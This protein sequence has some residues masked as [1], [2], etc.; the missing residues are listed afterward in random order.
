MVGFW[1][2]TASRP[3]RFGLAGTGHLWTR[4]TLFGQVYTRCRL[5]PTLNRD[6]HRTL[7][8]QLNTVW[9]VRDDCL[10]PSPKPRDLLTLS[11]I[12]S[13]MRRRMTQL[14]VSP[15]DNASRK[16]QFSVR[17]DLVNAC[18]RAEFAWVETMDVDDRCG[19]SV[20]NMTAS[21]RPPAAYIDLGYTQ[22]AYGDG[23]RRHRAT[24]TS[25]DGSC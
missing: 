5:Y 18:F 9:K 6:R 23:I 16:P 25:H 3:P 4:T 21:S 8:L 24:L 11:T 10:E 7:A 20:D 13:D 14:L 15:N 2:P 22:T 19:V 17:A 1:S 12:R